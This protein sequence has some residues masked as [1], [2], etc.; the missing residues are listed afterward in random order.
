MNEM[1]MR[2]RWSRMYDLLDAMKEKK[3]EELNEDEDEQE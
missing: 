3:G 2:E 1:K